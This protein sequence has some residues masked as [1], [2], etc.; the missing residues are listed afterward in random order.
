MGV[1]VT[2]LFNPEGSVGQSPNEKL[3]CPGENRLRI[4]V[5]NL[6]SNRIAEMERQGIKWRIFKDANIAS[7]TGQKSFSF[8]DWPTD[9]SGLNSRVTLTP[10]HYETQN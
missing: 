1:S 10:I 9:P 6:P 2:R 3:F 7:V 5:T 4:E 8:G